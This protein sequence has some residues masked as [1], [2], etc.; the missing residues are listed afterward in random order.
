MNQMSSRLLSTRQADLLVKL[1]G[2]TEQKAKVE[3]GEVVEALLI[4]IA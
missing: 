2:R 3:A 1:P 4:R